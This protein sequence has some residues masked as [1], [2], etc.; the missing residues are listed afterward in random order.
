MILA[1]LHAE[2]NTFD[3]LFELDP[4][5]GE[6]FLLWVCPT[7]SSPKGWSSRCAG[8]SSSTAVTNSLLQT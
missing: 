7:R 2:W 5:T 4:M 3:R 6:L 8:A 1:N